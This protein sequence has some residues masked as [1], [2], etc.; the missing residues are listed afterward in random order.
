MQVSGSFVFGAGGTEL[1]THV[2]RD[3]ADNA[4]PAALLTAL[5]A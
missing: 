1:F 2:S 3:F 5:G 4:L